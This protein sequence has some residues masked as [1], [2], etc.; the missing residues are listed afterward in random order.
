[1]KIVQIM[2]TAGGI[3]G[4]EQHTFN[5]T[6]ALAQHHDV[7]VIAHES[8]KS[9]FS[10]QV[11]FCALDFSKSRFS[12]ILLWQ[13]TQLI[14][15]I[16]PQIIHAQAGKASS[17][18][19]NI[20]LFIGDIKC[21]TTVHGTKKDKSPYL[22]GD[23]IIA[24]SKGLSEY[25]PPEK[26]HIIYN[27]VAWHVPLDISEQVALKQQ[28]Y[29]AH[30]QLHPNKK[31]VI[32]IG[33]LEAV[34]NISLLLK[35]FQKLD[36][37]LWIVGSGS[38]RE[39]LEQL[40]K[41]LNIKNQ[42]AFLG[43]RKDA[44]DLLQLADVVALSSDRE[45]FPLVMVEALQAEKRMVSTQVNGV[46]EWLPSCCLAPIQNEHA[47]HHALKMALEQ[48]ELDDLFI[49]LYRKAQQELTVNA[50]MRKTEQVYQNL[51]S[52]KTDRI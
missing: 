21:V 46:S 37:N 24:V 9:C 26:T 20:K 14:K 50:M 51:L 3:G 16:Q 39:Q 11:Q 32:C 44:R 38:E 34:K 12:P 22:V 47:L 8:Y 17:L 15:K 29:K 33:R 28:V 43:F 7:T 18:L 35:A 6:N 5:L 52:S 1:M 27:G 19:K 23:A 41:K 13:L 2:A 30:P 49:P 31:T 36:A 4:L 42:V 10:P 45:G 48:K 40:A 25:L